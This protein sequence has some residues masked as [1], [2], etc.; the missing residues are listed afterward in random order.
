MKFGVKLIMMTMVMLV[1]YFVNCY[2]EDS[3]TYTYVEFT[4]NDAPYGGS[5]HI[6]QGED[7]DEWIDPVRIVLPGWQGSKVFQIRNY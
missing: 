3:W 2:A 4:S 1:E 7:G 5:I 6:E